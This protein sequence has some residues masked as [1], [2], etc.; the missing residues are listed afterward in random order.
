MVAALSAGGEDEVVADVVAAP[1]PVVSVDAG[2]RT[3]PATEQYVWMC[4]R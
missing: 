1:E 2:A 3:Y 4:E